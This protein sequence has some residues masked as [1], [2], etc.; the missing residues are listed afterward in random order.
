MPELPEV[1]ITR[2]GIAPFLESAEIRR[3]VVRNRSLRWPVPPSL[4]DRVTGR[5]IRFVDRR[6]KYLLFGMDGGGMLLHLGMS[7]SLRVLGRPVPP[8]GPHDH[9]DLET[10]DGHTMRFRDPRRFGCLLWQPGAIHHHP[11]LKELGV[12]P[13]SAEFNGDMLWAGGRFRRTAIKNILMN[14]RVVVGVGNI[15]ASEALFDAGIHPARTGNR[16]TRRRYQ[17]LAS[18]VRA[19]L[20]QAIEQGGTTLRDF[21]GATGNPGYFHRSLRVYGREGEPCERCRAPVRRVVT[22]QRAT[23]YCPGCQR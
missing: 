8:P 23:F 19:T 4:E 22:G 10:G 16:I 14:A 1:E 11:L 7:G 2:R 9:F 21:T 12:E 6:G 13:L 5:T 17:A 3:L 18:A 15:Y 20:Q